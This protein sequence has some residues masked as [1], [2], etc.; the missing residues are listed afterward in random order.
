MKKSLFWAGALGS[1]LIASTFIAPPSLAQISSKSQRG[2]NDLYI[3]TLLGLHNNAPRFGFEVDSVMLPGSAVYNR[4]KELGAN[5]VRINWRVSWSAMQ[6]SQGAAIDFSSL[7]DFEKM[8]RGLSDINVQ[9]AVIVDDY[10]RWATTKAS[11]CAPIR[12]DRFADFAEYM[13]QM[14]LRYKSPPFN[15]KMWELGNEPD[16][17]FGSAIDSN[18]GCWGNKSDASFYGGAAYGAMLK[19]VAPAI[20][21]ADPDAKILIGGL[22]LDNNNT[23]VPPGEGRPEMFFAGILSSGAASSF[24]IAAYHGY[25]YYDG[26]DIDYSGVALNNKWV[27]SN[28]S[29]NGIARGKP[30]WLKD[31]MALY[32]TNKPLSLNEVALVCIAAF[33]PQACNNPSAAFFNAQANYVAPAIT[34]AF[35][36]GVE[37]VVWYTLD[38]PGWN[39][40]GLLDGDGNP[41]PAF[42]AYKTLIRQ[43]SGS[44]LPPVAINYGN[45]LEGYRFQRG[46]GWVDVVWSLDSTPRIV[47]VPQPQFISAVDRDGNPISPTLNGIDAN[48]PVGLGGIYITRLP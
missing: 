33:F 41:R 19:A 45:G 22:L 32:N 43:L 8:L 29:R 12:A 40:V 27:N 38:G 5:V 34:R 2:P 42:F 11:N 25:S 20:R 30:N 44:N 47:R 36:N 18:F 7:S 48:L 13:R 39:N 35:A 15:V 4:A 16:V 6:P 28:L 46:P 23:Q 26:R 17:D 1:V 9:P 10:P 37:Q 3:P 21:Q 14:V 31:A 24:D